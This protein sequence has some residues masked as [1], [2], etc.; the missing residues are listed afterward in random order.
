MALALRALNGETIPDPDAP[1]ADPAE[2][3]TKP[4]GQ[5]PKE[6]QKAKSP[7]GWTE[8]EASK[9]WSKLKDQEQRF[10]KRIATERA[11]AE[12]AKTEATELRTKYE[13]LE[14]E[15]T[16]RREHARTKPLEALAQIGWTLPQLTKYLA[17]NG[18]VPPDK[19]AA[20]LKLEYEGGFK[21]LHE[22]QESLKKTIEEQRRTAAAEQT[23]A[24]ARQYENEARELV[25]GY[26]KSHPQHFALLSRIPLEVAHQKALDIQTA[27]YMA[28]RQEIESGRENPLALPD[29]MVYA[30]REL[31]KIASWGAFSGSAGQA[32]TGNAGKPGAAKPV[33]N[34]T[35]SQS[36]HSS[37]TVSPPDEEDISEE[38]L[39]AKALR[40][41]NTGE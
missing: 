6:E 3:P 38:A 35:L 8:E 14:K 28:R 31:Q 2:E 32:G 5:K 11:E 27:D 12:K 9:S 34:P 24:Q 4:E 26:F 37:R 25:Q 29:A 10:T 39:M 40:M 41:L 21:K 33:E 36:D 16:Q 30:E 20:D 19:L 23:K 1:A 13:G 17:D 7:D 22:E 15:L 18:A